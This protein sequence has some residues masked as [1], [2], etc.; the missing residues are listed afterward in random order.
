[1]NKLFWTI[2]GATIG[3][4]AGIAWIKAGSPG[5]FEGIVT[6]FGAAVLFILGWVW[7]G[8]RIVADSITKSQRR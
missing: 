7:R 5:G 6:A 4:I 2:V 3:F 1:M 8:A